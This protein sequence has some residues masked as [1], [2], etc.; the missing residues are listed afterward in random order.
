MVLAHVRNKAETLSH[1]PVSFHTATRLSPDV[2]T[3]D[4]QQQ[5]FICPSGKLPTLWGE[6]RAG[7]R[8][9]LTSN[10]TVGYNVLSRP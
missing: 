7:E 4:D 6:L 8:G 3:P 5:T 10:L 9:C 1:V 2:F